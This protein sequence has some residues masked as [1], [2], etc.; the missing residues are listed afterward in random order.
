MRLHSLFL[1]LW[2]HLDML[3]Q[4]TTRYTGA[5]MQLFQMHQVDDC[6]IEKEVKLKS[7]FSANEIWA[8]CQK[9]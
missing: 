1:A 6:Q 3:I 8:Q 2:T 4:Y 7:G 5:E 9:L